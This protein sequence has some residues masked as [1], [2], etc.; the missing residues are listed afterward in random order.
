MAIYTLEEKV[1]DHWS[2]L[3]AGR[4]QPLTKSHK[5]LY[6]QLEEIT[7]KKVVLVPI[8]FVDTNGQ[9]LLHKGMPFTSEETDYMLQLAGIPHH[10]LSIKPPYFKNSI[11]SIKS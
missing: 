6:E 9:E 4:F 1:K 7:G 3:I 8:F 5:E 10:I 11:D 2:I